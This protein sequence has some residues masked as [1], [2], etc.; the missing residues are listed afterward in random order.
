M[1]NADPKLHPFEAPREY[2][3]AVNAGLPRMSGTL[4]T[5]SAAV[6]TERI[7]AKPFIASLEGHKDGVRGHVLRCC[8]NQRR[9]TAWPSTRTG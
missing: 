4:S 1:K 6:K 5:E 2:Q 7:F 8:H 9:C 3:R